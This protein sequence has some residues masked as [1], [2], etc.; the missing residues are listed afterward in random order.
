MIGKSLVSDS[1]YIYPAAPTQAQPVKIQ[2][3]YKITLNK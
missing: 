1:I 3:L 2:V